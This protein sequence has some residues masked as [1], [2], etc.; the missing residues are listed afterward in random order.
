MQPTLRPRSIACLIIICFVVFW[1]RLGS[2]G[3]IDPDEPFYAET[4]REMVE[5]HDWITPRIFGQPQFEKPIAFYWMA[6]ASFKIFGINEFAA[7]L[8]SALFATL[9]VLMVYAFGTRVWNERAGFLSAL[10]LGTGLEFAVMSRLMLTDIALA[11]FIGASLFSYWSAMQDKARANRWLFSYFV[12]A[13]LAVLT[14][15]PIGWLVGSM[16][17]SAFLITGGRGFPFRGR[18]L[19]IG[20]ATYAAISVPWFAIMLWK[21]GWRYFNEFFI[22]ENVMRLIHAEHPTNNHFYYYIAILLGGSLP[23]VPVLL[24]TLWRARKG[25]RDEITAFLWCWIG[26]SFVFL[27]IAQS[28]LPSYIFFLFVPIA[29]CVGKTLDDF[30]ANGFRSTGERILVFVVSALQIA[31][32]FAAPL[33]KPARPFEMPAML[34]GGCLAIALV[35]LL[36]KQT[37]AWVTAH[38]IGTCLLLVGALTASREH[39]EEMSSAR[40][41]ANALMQARTGDEPIL[42]DKFL[43]RGIYFY[44]QQPVR[45]LANKAQPFWSAHP[46]PVVAGREQ[47]A[48]LLED[49]GTVLCALRKG[50]S[51]IWEKIGVFDAA[52]DTQAFGNNLLIRA[53]KHSAIGER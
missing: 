13:G 17:T 45:V 52:K 16:A 3:L 31:I 24:L 19:W 36:L 39:V 25:S 33:I 53:T 47:F 5:T 29:L 12:F 22:H 40:P 14:K 11:F 48:K 21:F 2:I 28:K 8:P 30:L 9:I 1:W 18:W 35:L 4:A 38:A 32:A 26:T 43:A 50:D 49:S 23:W 34:L 15:G 37:R 20:A 7:R 27:T 46:L 10:V 42:A 6:A 51:P 44:T 41:I